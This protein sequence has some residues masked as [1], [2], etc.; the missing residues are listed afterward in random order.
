MKR[1]AQILIQKAEKD[2]NI[3]K[4]LSIE[5]H[6]FLEGICFHCQQSV[7]KY[8]KAFLVCNN[9]EI[10]FTHDITAVLSDCHK[11]DIDFNKLKELNISNLTNYAVIVRYD[12]IIEPTLDD[13][14]EAI[15][16]AEKVKLFVIEKINL[17]EQKQTLYE[18]DA[19]TK[20]LNNRLNKGKGGPKLG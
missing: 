1:D 6:D 15:L 8:L 3:A 17:L 12:D 5:N 7:E 9:Q 13:A 2:L 11:I 19:F 10:N 4:S 20:D 16:I 18:E 14:K